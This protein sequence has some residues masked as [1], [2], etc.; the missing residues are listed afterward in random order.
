MGTCGTVSR[1]GSILT[2][3]IAQVIYSMSPRLAICL[4]G[5]TAAVAG[6]LCFLLPE[7]KDK[8][9]RVSV[10]ALFGPFYRYYIS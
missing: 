10:E 8:E 5:T 6:C 7:T 4:Y 2:A 3:F 9:L 1:V